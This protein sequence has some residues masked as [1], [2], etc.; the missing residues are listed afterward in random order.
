MIPQ[1]TTFLLLLTISLSA[2]RLI[3]FDF[4]DESD[5]LES[6]SYLDRQAWN[7]FVAC[8]VFPF[9]PAGGS[10]YVGANLR[11]QSS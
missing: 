7:D 8:I 1:K 2:S 9:L 5:R 6:P 3:D 4:P 10:R 11:C